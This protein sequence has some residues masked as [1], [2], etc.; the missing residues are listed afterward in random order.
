MPEVYPGD[1]TGGGGSGTENKNELFAVEHERSSSSFSR[2]REN[3]HYDARYAAQQEGD[4][5][6]V[7]HRVVHGPLGPH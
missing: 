6:A 3:E 4:G 1:N 2:S 7:V 5:N